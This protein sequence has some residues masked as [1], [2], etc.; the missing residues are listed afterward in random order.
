LETRQWY[1]ACE[2]FGVVED[3]Q[4]NRHLEAEK[5]GYPP[6]S[7]IFSLHT[8]LSILDS[9]RSRKLVSISEQLFVLLAVLL[10]VSGT[11]LFPLLYY[12]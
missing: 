12:L 11:T 8:F 3:V 10:I 4:S 9:A 5:A 1:G 7:F 6:Q 2:G